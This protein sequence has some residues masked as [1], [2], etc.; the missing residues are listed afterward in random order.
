MFPA[1]VL[2]VV[3]EALPLHHDGP[4]AK[5]AMPSIKVCLL[6]VFHSIHFTI[7][8]SFY[9]PSFASLSIVDMTSYRNPI[10]VG[11]NPG[12][13]LLI[14]Y[15][16]SDKCHAFKALQSLCNEEIGYT[17]MGSSRRNF[18]IWVRLWACFLLKD[19]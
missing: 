8:S 6:I 10:S 7:F 2:P 14:F 13:G 1:S 15:S 12:I 9:L 17:T 16:S 5:C 19:Q 4:L 11:S 3:R 18:V